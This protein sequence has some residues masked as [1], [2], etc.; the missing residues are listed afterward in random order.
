MSLYDA[1]RSGDYLKV[2]ALLEAGADANEAGG[3]PNAPPLFAAVTRSY[4]EITRLLLDWKAE[5]NVH[6]RSHRGRTPLHEAA[7][8]S[9]EIIALLVDRG[10]SLEAKDDMG[11]T[12]LHYAAT[13]PEKAVAAILVT[14]G[15]DLAVLNKYGWSPFH[16]ACLGGTVDVVE[17]LL[18]AGADVRIPDKDGCTP[19]HLAARNSCPGL[20]DLLLKAGAELNIKDPFGSTPLH[21]AIALGER[22]NALLLT[23]R[24]ADVQV[25]AKNL[26]TPLHMS[27]IIGDR[28]VAEAILAAGADVEA[29]T[30]DGWTALQLAIDH[31]HPDVLRCLLDHGASE[32]HVREPPHKPERL[33]DLCSRIWENALATAQNDLTAGP[34]NRHDGQA[35]DCCDAVS[36]APEDGN[37]LAASRSPSPAYQRSED[38]LNDGLT[39]L[40]ALVK[41]WKTIQ[42]R[43]LAEN[44]GW[45]R[46]DGLTDV[47]IV[48]AWDEK[49]ADQ[50]SYELSRHFWEVFDDERD[51]IKEAIILDPSAETSRII[52]DLYFSQDLPEWDRSDML[53]FLFKLPSWTW[54]SS[55]L[56]GLASTSIETV[57]QQQ[58]RYL[59]ALNHTQQFDD[60]AGINHVLEQWANQLRCR[61]AR[62]WDAESYDN[63]LYAA[64]IGV[65]FLT[66]KALLCRL[67]EL[68]S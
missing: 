43:R 20:I 59:V 4:F 53:E 27:A 33:Q 3:R 14:H 51:R 50:G 1:V 34:A 25:T 44:F 54:E 67:E 32:E 58:N 56:K 30:G 21:S 22:E 47:E 29:R 49:I 12:P 31:G 36:D 45:A 19:L 41:E 38:V 65:R 66:P 17:V 39:H 62:G 9:P 2:L 23:G 64:M 10:A 68:L 7:K 6:N 40:T 60:G 28:E 5:V 37:D 13:N 63:L 52:L 15:A 57:W 8:G 55:F 61:L 16:E 24:G 18:A 48:A 46:L 35:C 11:S 42:L 26:L